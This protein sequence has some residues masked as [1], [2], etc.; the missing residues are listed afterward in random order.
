MTN[1][2]PISHKGKLVRK[3]LSSTVIHFLVIQ[4]SQSIQTLSFQGVVSTFKSSLR[5]QGAVCTVEVWFALLRCSFH[6]EVWFALLRCN[7]HF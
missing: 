4:F 6:F 2:N 1:R 7:V 3:L 5:F